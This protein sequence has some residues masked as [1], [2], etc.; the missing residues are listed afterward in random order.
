MVKTIQDTKAYALLKKRKSPFLERI[1]Q[2]YDQAVNFLPKINRVFADYTGHDIVHS[3]NV[4]DYMF[5]I[6]DHPELLS[7]LEL[8]VLVYTALL[9]DTGM[10]VSEDEINQIEKDSGN[11]TP[12]KYSLVLKKYQ[13]ETIALQECIRPVHGQ[14][15]F[16]YVMVMSTHLFILPGYT[17][18]S[19]QDDVAKIC[20]VHNENFA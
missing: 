13:D 17:N 8:T 16:K 6:C 9:H 1:D 2:V 4:A 5:A 11:I 18:I 12:R 15:S 14:R 3:L 20:A 7:D 10:V 19:F